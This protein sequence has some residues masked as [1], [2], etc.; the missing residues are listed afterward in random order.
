MYFT[1]PNYQPLFVPFSCSRFNDIVFFLH[2]LGNYHSAI[3]LLIT[4]M[5]TIADLTP[6]NLIPLKFKSVVDSVRTHTSIFRLDASPHVDI[7]LR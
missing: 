6:P 2:Q 1:N 3:P 5:G 4:V 7:H